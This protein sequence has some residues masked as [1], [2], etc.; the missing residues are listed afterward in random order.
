M[1]LWY[2]GVSVVLLALNLFMLVFWSD[3]KADAEARADA[4]AE[5][6]INF[7]LLAWGVTVFFKEL[8]ER[9]A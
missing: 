5:V 4:H 3:E 8:N 6:L 2:V 1:T 9:N 7:A